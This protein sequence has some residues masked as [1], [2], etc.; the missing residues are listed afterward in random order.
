MPSIDSNGITIEY[1][2]RGE[3]PPLLFIVGLS[4]QLTDWPADFLDLF[5]DRGFQVIT[6]DNRDSG[7]STM[8]DWE[9]P[10]LWRQ[11]V[12][13]VLRRPVKNVNYTLT[14]MAADTA[15]LLDGL[16][17]ES[18]HVVGVSMGGMIA[19]ELAIT[20]PGRVRSL[21]SV[22]SNTS[23][24]RNG[25]ISPSLL[26]AGRPAAPT[27]ETAVDQSVE[28]F[29]KLAGPHFDEVR[30]RE[31]VSRS[32]ERSFS[33]DGVARQTAAVSGSRDRTELLATVTA[34]TLV[35]HGLVD[36]LVRFSGAIA[37]AQAIPDSRLLAFGDMGHD[38][39]RP[40]WEEMVDAI[41]TNVERAGR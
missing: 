30:F 32:I 41:V 18:T 7:L 23:D 35:I 12:S 1:A 39:P 2:T 31:M 21:C 26:T 20:R 33:P 25:G 37:T 24:R 3:G 4:G 17:I 27:R 16:G 5:V 38:L 6:F 28:W 40:R 22:M 15:G 10:S 29:R 19:Q 11:I 36:P 13:L 14:D 34:P 8:T 9:P